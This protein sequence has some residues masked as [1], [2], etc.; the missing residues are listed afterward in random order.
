MTMPPSVRASSRPFSSTW[1]W[2]LLTMRY[3]DIAAG[4]LP[5]VRRDDVLDIADDDV[6]EVP[7]LTLAAGDLLGDQSLVGA[8][9]RGPLAV[10]RLGDD[11]GAHPTHSAALGGGGTPG[12]GLRVA[13]DRGVRQ[14]PVAR[15]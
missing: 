6:G 7:R 15:R 14:V 12:V 9:G 11:L 10:E 8:Q 13:V 5:D 2:G 1:L 4:P 3:L